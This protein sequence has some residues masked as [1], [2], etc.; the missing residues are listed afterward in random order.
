MVAALGLVVLDVLARG[1]R[2]GGKGGRMKNDRRREELRA[3]LSGGGIRHCGV[4]PT[5]AP[6]CAACWE[7]AYGVELNPKPEGV[8]SQ[9]LPGAAILAFGVAALLLAVALLLGW[10]GGVR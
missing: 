6:R 2:A 1:D 4:H 10:V 8:R 5:Y 3:M 7:A 9:E